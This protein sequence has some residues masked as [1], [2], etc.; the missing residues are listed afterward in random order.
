GFQSWRPNH[1]TDIC[2]LQPYQC[3]LQG[4][5]LGSDGNLARRT[6]KV[7]A[8]FRRQHFS[9]T[10][11][12]STARQQFRSRTARTARITERDPLTEKHKKNGG[13]RRNRRLSAT[14]LRTRV[15]AFHADNTGSNPVGDAKF[16]AY[17]DEDF[18]ITS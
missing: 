8:F 4:G 6:Q 18:A 13:F 3:S 9:D 10:V 12:L 2:R 16:P 7:T 1:T 5:P 17:L 14:C 15:L 11:P